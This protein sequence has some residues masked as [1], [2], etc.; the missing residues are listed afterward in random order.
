MHTLGVIQRRFGL[1]LK[2]LLDERGLAQ[3]FFAGS[4]GVS[5]GTLSNWLNSKTGP[6]LDK[7]ATIA[8]HLS[9]GPR[10][11]EVLR[12][13]AYLARSPTLVENQFIDL[14]R[15]LGELDLDIGDDEL[16]GPQQH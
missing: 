13:L 14:K 11:A 5:T 10:E 9:L 7:L 8:E 3:D 1:Y 2:R 15:R 4:I 12:I 16:G 6:S